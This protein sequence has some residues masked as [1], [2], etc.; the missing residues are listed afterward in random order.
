MQEWTMQ[1]FSFPNGDPVIEK[2]M[3]ST[4]VESISLYKDIYI[5]ACIGPCVCER[6]ITNN[7]IAY[8]EQSFGFEHQ[9]DY[10]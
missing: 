2:S 9:C 5:W 1:Y 4:F 3:V 10:S 6:E 7:K 8:I